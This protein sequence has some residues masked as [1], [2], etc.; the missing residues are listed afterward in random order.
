[1]NISHDI[2]N[3]LVLDT[4]I[5]EYWELYFIIIIGIIM[6]SNGIVYMNRFRVWQ[7]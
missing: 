3:S 6:I 1:L 4:N 2:F 7:A 5:N